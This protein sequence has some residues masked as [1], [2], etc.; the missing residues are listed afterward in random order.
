[1]IIKDLRILLL[2]HNLYNSMYA[3]VYTVYLC[4]N[5][6]YSFLYLNTC[7]WSKYF[8]YWLLEVG[9]AA[10]GSW[11]VYNCQLFFLKTRLLYHLL[12]HL[13]T[14]KVD[15]KNYCHLLPVC[16]QKTWKSHIC[17]CSCHVSWWSFL[18]LFIS[19]QM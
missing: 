6:H 9:L 14:F 16:C 8:G 5:L 15:L 12:C 19:R 11:N 3:C 10:Q 7:I 13:H 2:L 4:Q 17:N 1:M 18:S